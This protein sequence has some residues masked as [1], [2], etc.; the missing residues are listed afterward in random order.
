[1]SGPFDTP[2][3]FDGNLLPSGAIGGSITFKPNGWQH[4]NIHTDGAHVSYDRNGG[5]VRGV[6]GTIQDATG[7][8]D[9]I[10]VVPR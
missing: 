5:H 2:V 8:G 1:M 3:P 7:R 6:H 4:V 9:K 10:I